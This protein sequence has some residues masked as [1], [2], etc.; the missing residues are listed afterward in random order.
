MSR[1]SFE[2][3]RVAAVV[4][5]ALALVLGGLGV[6]HAQKGSQANAAATLK[7]AD[8]SEGPSRT[9]FAP[10]VKAVVPTVVS[11]KSS[12]VVKT[13]GLNNGQGQ[14]DPLFRQFFGDQFGGQFNAKFP[15]NSVPRASV[16]A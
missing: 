4:V 6:A 1:F 5:L 16:P 8:R 3:G 2:R 11:I 14:I 10:V 9:G 15:M 13:T 7:F 12:K